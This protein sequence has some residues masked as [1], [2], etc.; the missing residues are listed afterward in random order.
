MPP[1]ILVADDN[2]TVQRMASEMLT[3][4][5]MDVI[6]VANGM[7]AIKKLPDVKPLVVVADVDMPGKN[8]YE[9]CDFVKSQPELGYVRVL[10][11]VSDSDPL[12]G[13]R[14]VE[15]RADGVVKKPFDRQAFVSI[16]MKSLGEAQALCPPPAAAPVQEQ[17]THSELLEEQ[18]YKEP[19]AAAPADEDRTLVLECSPMDGMPAEA[20]GIADA[21]SLSDDPA[22]PQLALHPE[23]RE[24]HLPVVGVSVTEPAAPRADAPHLDVALGEPEQDSSEPPIVD[25]PANFMAPLDPLAEAGEA[26][27]GALLG[28][29]DFALLEPPLPDLAPPER[30]MISSDQIQTP[31]GEPTPLPDLQGM[32]DYEA[33]S[34]EPE[35]M[36][37]VHELT[38]R[39]DPVEAESKVDVK[40]PLKPVIPEAVESAGAE[41]HESEAFIQ[42]P[43]PSSL[44]DRNDAPS[45]ALPVPA[46]PS[47]PVNF[48]QPGQRNSFDSLPHAQPEDQLGPASPSIDAFLVSSIIHAVVRRMAPPA[49]PDDALE[50]L[51]RQLAAEIMPD[52]ILKTTK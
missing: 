30:P 47:G 22:Q 32:E 46:I 3:E 10:L 6:T 12:D 1:T 45:T 40:S 42:E 9:V 52:L 18:T 29:A 31:Q 36:P 4:E 37:Q 13:G 25:W 27:S 24:S 50:N 44:G 41:S 28:N 8:G 11:V 20:A 5:G 15:V 43:L 35:S 39:I 17:P 2:L 7:A 21:G 23:A 16:V 33:P 49:L 51:E 14:G 38:P 19:W 48:G 26:Q 34:I